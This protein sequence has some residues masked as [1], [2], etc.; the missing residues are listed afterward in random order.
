MSVTHGKTRVKTEH[1]FQSK[2]DTEKQ[3]LRNFIGI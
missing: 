3:R 2:N 1:Y